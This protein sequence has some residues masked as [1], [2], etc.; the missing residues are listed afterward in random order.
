MLDG[1][2]SRSTTPGSAGGT[3]VGA[4]AWV[5]VCRV[6]GAGVGRVGRRVAAGT[7]DGAMT[8]TSGSVVVS[9]AQAA[10]ASAARLTEPDSKN[11]KPRMKV[12]RP[13]YAPRI[14]PPRPLTTLGSYPDSILSGLGRGPSRCFFPKPTGNFWQSSLVAGRLRRRRRQQLYRQPDQVRQVAGVK[15]LLELRRHVHD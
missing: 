2:L 14:L 11:K 13:P 5:R 4:G 10:P 3:G 9:C 7:G 1:T 15:L 8:R 12:M 6:A